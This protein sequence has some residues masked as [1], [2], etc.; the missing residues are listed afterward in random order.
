MA[1]Y[2]YRCQGCQHVFDVAHS[3][4]STAIVLCPACEDKAFRIVEIA[5][6]VVSTM[7]QK[8]QGS[9]SG[10]DSAHKEDAGH[11]G[12]GCGCAWHSCFHQK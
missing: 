1:E 11:P 4:H 8:A 7:G 10:A 5:P 2:R 12:H 9:S 3:V 6:A